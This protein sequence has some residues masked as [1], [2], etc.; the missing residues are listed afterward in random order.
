MSKSKVFKWLL[1]LVLGGAVVFAA[2]LYYV[3]FFSSSAYFSTDEGAI[4]GYDTVAYFTESKAVKG[5]KEFTTN[6]NNAD[7]YFS[8]KENLVLFK[9]NPEKYA[10]Q[11]GGYCAYALAHEHVA[12]TDPEAWKIVDD[13]L[14]L[15]YNKGVQEKWSKDI[16]GF[17][18]KADDYWPKSTPAQNLN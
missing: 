10:P 13:R 7:W 16:P 17:I 9:Q 4:R 18:K 3:G 2:V 5:S 8:S 12:N 14:F 15:N 11:Y 6:W 1:F